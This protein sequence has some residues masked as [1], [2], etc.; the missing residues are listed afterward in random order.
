[1]RALH[2]YLLFF[3]TIESQFLSLFLCHWRKNCVI[4][5][6]CFFLSNDRYLL[7]KKIHLMCKYD[8]FVNQ[9]CGY[10]IFSQILL[11]STNQANR[12]QWFCKLSTIYFTPRAIKL[13]V[14]NTTLMN[15]SKY[16]TVRQ[17]VQSYMYL[18]GIYTPTNRSCNFTT[19]EH[20]RIFI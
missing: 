1:M 12:C 2:H 8:L 5:K 9:Y 3:H 13:A 7:L 15:C 18:Y 6:K 19:E 20:Q 17:V 10:E 11:P 14:I 4:K 16:E